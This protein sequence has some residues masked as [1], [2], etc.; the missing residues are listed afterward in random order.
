MSTVTIQVSKQDNSSSGLRYGLLDVEPFEETKIVKKFGVKYR[1]T[2]RGLKPTESFNAFIKFNTGAVLGSFQMPSG[3]DQD[4]VSKLIAERRIKDYESDTE[5]TK[6][7]EHIEKTRSR[8]NVGHVLKE[9]VQFFLDRR[10][11]TLDSMFE[12]YASMF[13]HSDFPMSLIADFTDFEAT[14]L[15]ALELIQ[16]IVRKHSALMGLPELH[17]NFTKYLRAFDRMKFALSPIIE[18]IEVSSFKEQSLRWF[19]ILSNAKDAGS[20]FDGEFLSRAKTNP[21]ELKRLHWEFQ[22]ESTALRKLVMQADVNYFKPLTEDNELKSTFDEM[23]VALT[24]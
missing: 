14:Y 18:Q 8:S 21:D 6:V 9:I 13:M 10:K 15:A 19:M 16:A 7:L 4:E 2:I 11:S 1:E 20:I 24:S 5:L 12:G 22:T 17:S 3:L 23:V